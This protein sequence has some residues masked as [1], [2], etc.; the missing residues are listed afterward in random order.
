MGGISLLKMPGEKLEEM[1]NNFIAKRIGESSFEA[2][3]IWYF[4]VDDTTILI[5][6]YASHDLIFT[7]KAKLSGNDLELVEV[8]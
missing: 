8:S 1:I 7:V 6:I 4:I 5:K 2:S 3:E